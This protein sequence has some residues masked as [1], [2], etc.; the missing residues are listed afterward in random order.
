MLTRHLFCDCIVQGVID[1]IPMLHVLEQSSEQ[2]FVP[3]TVGGGIR[4]YT[5]PSGKHN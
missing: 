2:V 1:D 5:E 4:G 3:L